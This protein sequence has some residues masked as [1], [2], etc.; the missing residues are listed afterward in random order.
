MPYTG[1]SGNKVTF[2]VWVHNR[3]TYG[4]KSYITYTY[5]NFFDSFD[6]EKLIPIKS[7][8]VNAF[9]EAINVTRD[10]YGLDQVKFSRKISK[11]ML[12]ENFDFNETKTAIMDIND[13]IN[14]A[15]PGDLLDHVNPLIVNI[16]DLDLVQYEGSL[17]AGSYEEFLEWARLLY[18]LENL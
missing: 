13:K 16:N 2:S 15:D 11:D 1:V 3:C 14:N 4:P 17:E 9:R 6:E 8:H 18:I 10:A 12:F 5:K 7:S